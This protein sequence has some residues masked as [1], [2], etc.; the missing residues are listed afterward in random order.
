MWW[1]IGTPIGIKRYDSVSEEIWQM[2]AYSS[3]LRTWF[4]EI[5]IS[6]KN[7]K[8][9]RKKPPSKIGTSQRMS[10]WKEMLENQD[11]LV[12]TTIP[13]NVCVSLILVH[14]KGQH[15]KFNVNTVVALR[16]VNKPPYTY[17][18][19][20]QLHCSAVPTCPNMPQHSSHSSTLR[21]C[22]STAPVNNRLS[23][24]ALWEQEELETMICAMRKLKR[25]QEVCAI[26]PIYIDCLV[27]CPTSLV[28]ARGRLII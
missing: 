25:L 1:R 20:A 23:T 17:Q 13:G 24:L 4:L 6:K 28:G 18:H 15:I 21:A 7:K 2:C 12:V 5:Q 9:R 3:S 27:Y 19:A 10:H 8:T 11:Q 22:P 26:G 16:F 14:H